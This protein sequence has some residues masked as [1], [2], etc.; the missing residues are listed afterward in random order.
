MAYNCLEDD[1]D[2]VVDRAPHSTHTLM[3]VSD[4]DDRLVGVLNRVAASIL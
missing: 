1:Y 4:V 2:T 3:D